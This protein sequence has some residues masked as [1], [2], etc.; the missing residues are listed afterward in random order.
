MMIMKKLINYINKKSDK[1]INSI[2]N[3]TN[4][5]NYLQIKVNN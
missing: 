1:N 4:I 3:M 5:Y 2:Y